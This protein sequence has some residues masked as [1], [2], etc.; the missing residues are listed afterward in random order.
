M[1]SVG[2]RMLRFRLLQMQVVVHTALPSKVPQ[3]RFVH[4]ESGGAISF[5]KTADEEPVKAEDVGRSFRSTQN[6]EVVLE[7]GEFDE[8]IGSKRNDLAIEQMLRMPDVPIE[9]FEKVNYLS[10]SAGFEQHFMLF[11]DALVELEV[12][13]VTRYMGKTGLRQS[14]AFIRPY[15]ELLMLHQARYPQ[16]LSPP[17]Q[18]KFPESTFGK[19]ERVLTRQLVEQMVR[20]Y[21]P[22]IY[23]NT[24]DDE[25]QRFID[26]RA[27]GQP[28]KVV[29]PPRPVINL[30]QALRQSVQEATKSRPARKMAPS[31]RTRTKKDSK[32]SK[33]A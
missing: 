19:E 29:A 2:K 7:P 15:G 30:M 16:E 5:K 3:S 11:R 17:P 18:V 24:L 9:L 20:P 27:E 26:D 13:A 31:K 22:A 10:P 12:M 23:A 8:L 21:D 1:A 4:R 25:V 6:Q 33:R 28:L 14:L 32:K